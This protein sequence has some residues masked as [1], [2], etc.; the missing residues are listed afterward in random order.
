MTTRWSS[1][2]RATS[3][4]SR[5]S[6]SASAYG[7]R[8]LAFFPTY[9]GSAFKNKG[10]QQ[11][12]NAV[13]D[14]LPDPTEVP[15]QPEIDLEGHETG[16][17]ALVDPSGPVRALAF[18]IMEDRFGALTF[19]RIYSGTVNKGDTLVNT[20][21]G[22]NERIGRMVEMHADDRTIVDSA[23]AGDIVAMVG[24]KD[25]RT[26]H[27][28][29]DQKN[30]ATLE[31]M[32]FP[33]PVI[34]LAIST[35]DKAMSEKL[36]TALG[37]MVAE[38]PSFHVEVD[39][40]S[41]ETILKGMGELHLDIKVD[42]LRRSHGVAVDVGAPQVAYRETVTQSDRGQLHAQEA[43]RWFWSVC[44]D[45]IHHRAHRARRR[46]RLR[47][48]DRR[49][50]DP[51]GVHSRRREGLQGHEGGGATVRIPPARLQAHTE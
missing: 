37:K 6:R 44:E 32:V 25:V 4:T 5:R 24:L 11:V 47:V 49:R 27:T 34:S 43:D 46:L 16:D 36:G 29:A 20:F 51:Q 14:Y 19:T 26:G 13:V 48:Q 3:L 10:I 35:K 45:R 7:T 2:S 12:L 8:D 1:T 18:K 28:L 15:P 9:C 33:D 50:Q 31:P 38:D 39:Q 42:I 41:G 30:P 23:Q 21:T 22:K 17:F 40:E